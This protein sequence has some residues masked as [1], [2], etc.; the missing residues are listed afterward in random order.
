MA[1]RP[2]APH[3]NIGQSSPSICFQ[4]DK[5]KVSHEGWLVYIS[6][7]GE[8]VGL[9][10]FNPDSSANVAQTSIQPSVRL[11]CF[12]IYRPKVPIGKPHFW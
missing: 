6:H 1:A 3:F 5:R 10:K 2:L 7:L 4:K 12:S 8:V 11:W 9:Y